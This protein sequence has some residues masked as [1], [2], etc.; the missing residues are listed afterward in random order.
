MGEVGPPLLPPHGNGDGGTESVEMAVLQAHDADLVRH[1]EPRT[2]DHRPPETT[3]SLAEHAHR[4]DSAPKEHDLEVGLAS[5]GN[6]GTEDSG[7]KRH[8]TTIVDWDG[9]E[10][11]QNPINWP[12]SFKWVNI[13]VIS[14]ITFIT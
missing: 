3:D 1:T 6:S 7:M 9:P 11:P 14:S 2:E 4:E 13:A 8:E 10:D 5:S 12:A